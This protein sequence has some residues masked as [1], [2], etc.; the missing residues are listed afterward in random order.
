MK[1]IFLTG[2]T[3]ENLTADSTLISADNDLITVDST[4]TLLPSNTYQIVIT[5]RELIDTI[6]LITINEL[7]KNKVEQEVDVTNDNGKMYIT[8][9]L[10]NV[11]EGDIFRAVVNDLDN[12]LLW[13]GKIL[14]T[15]QTDVQNYT[16][17]VPSTNNVIKM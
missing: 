7:T 15:A 9:E 1:I 12:N 2:G 13:R 6:K 16:L 14:A 11:K 8:F 3:Q 17:N 5:P 10:L 4:F